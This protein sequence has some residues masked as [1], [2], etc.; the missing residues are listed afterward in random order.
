MNKYC[1]PKCALALIFAAL[2]PC[3]AGAVVFSSSDN[4]F[5]IDLPSSW[6]KNDSSDSVLSLKRDDV[7]MKIVRIKGCGDNDCL[8]K[9][10]NKEL[11]SVKA[12]KFNI[13]ENTYTGDIVKRTEFSTGD[14]LY[15]FNFSAASVDF[16]SAY[17]LADGKAYNVGIKGLPYVEADLVL[18]FISPAAKET[19]ESAGAFRSDD[20]QVSDIKGGNFDLEVG[21]DKN[22][23]G[24]PS[25]AK[26]HHHKINFPFV[27]VCAYILVLLGTLS[28]K[29][30]MRKKEEEEN[31]NPRSYYPV[32]GSR[33]YGSPDLFLKLYDNQGNNYVA[34]S[35]RWG[36]IFIGSGALL[37]ILFTVGKILLSSLKNHGFFKIHMILTNTLFSLSSLCTV[38]GALIF[39]AGCLINLLFAYKFF[40]YD[41]NG[42]T[43]YKCIQKG[44][45]FLREDY[46]VFDVKSAVVFR[47]KR[48]RFQLLRNW[49]IYNS[50]GTIAVIRE[51]GKR[52]AIF[53]MLFG[54]LFGFLRSAYVIEGRLDSK[55]TLVSKPCITSSFK[56]E[57]DKPQA[58]DARITLIS[59]AIIFMRDR[60]KW[61]P[62][63][64]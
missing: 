32:N 18:S 60:D 41:K 4:S 54:H 37:F 51:T 25:H 19:D 5:T 50:Q 36:N 35:G 63:V 62:W 43:L 64:N 20:T 26:R 23:S 39:M 1:L 13:L 9:E 58:I 29:F 6:Q 12:Q 24:A 47:L 45:H 38:F 11:E 61:H 48:D 7:T 59:S 42:Y 27:I 30:F 17:F 28:A 55:G 31:S 46:V 57:L 52:R 21:D 40:I 16:T 3:S 2:I 22:S 10:V 49:V 53:R 14:P 8:A 44:F 56:A 34:T 33:L 15:S